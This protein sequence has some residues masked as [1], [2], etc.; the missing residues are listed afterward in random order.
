MIGTLLTQGDQSVREN[1]QN[2]GIKSIYAAETPRDV[3]YAA[4]NVGKDIMITG[5][6]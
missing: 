6:H 2:I 1:S 5:L 3:S 4:I